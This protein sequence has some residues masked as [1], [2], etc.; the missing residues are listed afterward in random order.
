MVAAL[1]FDHDG[2]MVDTE[3]ALAECIV[4]VLAGLGATVAFED[5]GHLFG[6]TEADAEWERLIPEW[7][8]RPVTL[9]EFEAAITPLFRPRA[10]TLPL[11]PGVAD[12]I[13]AGRA[14]GWKVG[15]ATGSSRDQVEARLDR[16]GVLSA[17]DAV[18]T[19]ADVARGKPA[20]DI[21][22]AAAERLG[23][24]PPA[25][26]VLEDSQP[27]CEA[28]VAA[29]MP[30]VLCPSAVSA[31]LEYPTAT[32]RVGSLTEVTFADLAGLLEGRPAPR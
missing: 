25:C 11:L 14:A 28:A 12:L 3:V 9:A 32:R 23:V 4:E 19:S 10:D 24:V 29:G 13:H 20:P 30:V 15:L 1:I 22:L 18:V 6:T 5:F 16:L 2:L 26:V 7:C 17:F 21:F 27:G 31:H 8:G